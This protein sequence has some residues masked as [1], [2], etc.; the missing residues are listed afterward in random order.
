VLYRFT[1]VSGAN[2]GRLGPLR[3]TPK[4]RCSACTAWR[5][6]HAERERHRYWEIP[7]LREQRVAAQAERLRD[8]DYRARKQAADRRRY[9]KHRRARATV[10]RRKYR[11]DRKYRE[12]RLARERARYR[13]RSGSSRAAQ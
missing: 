12:R 9:A 6:E 5:A 11:S 1:I 3:A 2:A 4:C 7:G 10:E 8:P 13:Q